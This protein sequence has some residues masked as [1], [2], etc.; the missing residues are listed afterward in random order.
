MFLHE[1]NIIHLCLY[2]N[3][4]IF[5]SAGGEIALLVSCLPLMLRTQIQILVVD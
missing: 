1:K 3:I 4:L 5:D 2:S